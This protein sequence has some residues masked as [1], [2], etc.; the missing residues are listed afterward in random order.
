MTT[1]FPARF[2]LVLA[3]NP[4]PCANT[5]WPAG[6]CCC[7]PAARRRYLGRLSGPLLD[8]AE[9]KAEVLPPGSGGYLRDGYASESSAAVSAR[10]AAARNRAAARLG[11]TP[12]LVNAHVPGSEL[13][14]Y[15]W[16]P[17]AAI[18]SAECALETGLLSERGLSSVVRVAWTIADL[19]GMDKPAR[20]QC[21]LAL[22]L[23]LG[24]GIRRNG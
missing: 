9:V 8:R 6:Q 21:E 20:E 12:W 7:S 4:C 15:W 17:A 3:A 10:V 16:P 18:T 24:G 14:R 5:A 22:E 13:R 2:T 1:S 23:V 11:S 19:A